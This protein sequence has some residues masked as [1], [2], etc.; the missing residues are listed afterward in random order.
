MWKTLKWSLLVLVLVLSIALAGVVGYAI[1]DNSGADTSASAGNYAILNEIQ[2]ILQEE[3]VNPDAV[4]TDSLT[5]GAID[6]MIASLNDPHSSYIPPDVLNSGVDIITG[7]FEGIGANVNQDPATHEI[8]IISPFRN[9]PAEKAGVKAGDVILAVD[10][11]STEGWSL[12]EAVNKIRGAEGTP[13]TLT[14]RHTDRTQQDIT[15]V[16]ETVNIPTVFTSDVTDA[17]G[18]DVPELAY[19][20]IQKFTDDTVKDMHTALEQISQ[21]GKKGLILDLRGNPGGGLDATVQVADMFL[22][23]GVVLTQVDRDGSKTVYNAE[24][25]GEAVNLQV[26]I[27]VDKYSASG[28]EVLSGA[29]HD[30]DRAKLI[31]T[32][33]F[34]KGSVNH[35]RTL[36]NG[37]AI[38]ISIARWLTPNGTLIEGVGLTPDYKMDQTDND[39]P[40]K[41][42]PQMFAAIDLLQSEINGT[43]FTP[44]PTPAATP[45]PVASAAP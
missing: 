44:P 33:T 29:L 17:S 9:S 4:K 35:L 15:I 31:G 36:S 32:Q 21:Q 16:R 30:H 37:G 18:A 14:L 41:V 6:G 23:G 24:P 45:T 1:N 12:T 19:I 34:G 8:V 42:G 11:E 25:G 20:Q 28:S 26:V 3:F 7:S 22:D 38:Y 43:P 10:G 2:G 27:L 39:A 40:G 5:N 13:V